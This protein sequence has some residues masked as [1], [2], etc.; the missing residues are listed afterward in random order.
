MRAAVDR[1]DLASRWLIIAAFA[2][3]VVVVS[4]QVLF[5]YFLNLSLDWADEVG[6]LTFVWAAFLGVPHGVKIG[7]HVGID[8]VAKM[9]PPAP[10]AWLFR[11]CTVAC[12]AL[13]AVVSWQSVVIARATWDQ[14]MPVLD[15]S[16]G[17]FYV[18]I[19]VAGAH[20]ALHFALL[21]WDHEPVLPAATIDA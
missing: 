8:F 1:L 15:F 10:L 21:A 4:L 3:M 7:A 13:M 20:S 2:A 9:L 5:R 19:T 14:L 16:T 11:A 6:R 12:A 18:A 17:W